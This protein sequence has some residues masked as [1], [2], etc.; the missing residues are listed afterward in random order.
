MTVRELKLA[1]ACG[2]EGDEVKSINKFF[3]DL[4]GDIK[5]YTEGDKLDLIFINGDNFI[6]KQDLE[7]GYLYCR[8]YGFWSILEDQYHCTRS[9]IKEIIQYKVGEKF[10]SESL[11]PYSVRYYSLNHV[12]E[13]YNNG[14]LTP[15]RIYYDIDWKVEKSYNNETLT[16]LKL[17]PLPVENIEK[18]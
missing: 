2:V 16:P 14:L 17:Y 12:E 11:I 18:I 15:M 8:Y 6:M 9:D 3:D 13:V 10:N 4:F 7:K 5:I 1:V